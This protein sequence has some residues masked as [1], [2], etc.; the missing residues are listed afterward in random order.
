MMLQAGS[1]CGI[2]GKVTH[3]TEQDGRVYAWTNREAE[4]DITDI[5]MENK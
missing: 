3:L 2:L 4:I 1:D 5:E